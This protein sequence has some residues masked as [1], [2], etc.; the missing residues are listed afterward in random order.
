M[1]D[2]SAAGPVKRLTDRSQNWSDM[3]NFGGRKV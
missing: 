3:H 1:L 2:F